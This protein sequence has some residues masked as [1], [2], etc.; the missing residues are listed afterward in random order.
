MITETAID[1]PQGVPR[2]CPVDCAKDANNVDFVAPILFS[3]WKSG[4][5]SSGYTIF[6]HNRALLDQSIRGQSNEPAEKDNEVE[7]HRH[8]RLRLYRIKSSPTI[9]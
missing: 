3:T 1:P 6:S 2:G 9:A 5:C 8:W 7:D 4:S